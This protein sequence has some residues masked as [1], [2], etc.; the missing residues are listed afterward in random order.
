MEVGEGGGNRPLGVVREESQG[1]LLDAPQVVEAG[2]RG[3]RI[4]TAGTSR[5]RTVGTTTGA[6]VEIPISEG[7]LEAAAAVIV[8]RNQRTLQPCPCQ[9]AAVIVHTVL[10]GVLDAPVAHGDRGK[11]V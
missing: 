4:A 2:A 10:V 7:E 1:G 3:V 6:K 5:S 8:G 9:A 11:A